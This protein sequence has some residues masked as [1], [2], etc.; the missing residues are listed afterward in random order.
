MQIQPRLTEDERLNLVAF[1][2]GEVDE[3]IA[4]G[5]EEK[6][7]KS[8]SVRREIQALEKTWGMLDWLPRPELPQDFASQ[9]VSRIHSQQLRAEIIEDRVKRWSTVAAKT[10]AWLACAAAMAAAG[11]VSVRHAW[12]DPTRELIELLP[13]VE[14]LDTYRS[15]PDVKFLNDISMLNMFKEPVEGGKDAAAGETPAAGS[16]TP[17]SPTGVPPTGPATK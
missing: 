3:D 9:T 2:D 4:R 5:L 17:Q 16:A 13:I 14:N 10:I 8:E 7:S 12:P 6:M 11:F 1:L 15:V